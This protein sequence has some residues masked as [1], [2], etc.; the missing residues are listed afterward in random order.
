M[1]RIYTRTGDQGQTRLFSG[2]RVSKGHVRVE[3]YGQVDELNATLGV[4][5][6]SLSEDYPELRE[7]LEG[8][9]A[10]L[11]PIGAWLATTPEA[12]TIKSLKEIDPA[13]VTAL[14]SAIDRMAADLPP[15]PG[16]VLPSGHESAARAHVARTV[17]RRAER[18]VVRLCE[19]LDESPVTE[20]LRQIITYLNR[21]SDYLF[22]LA[23]LC[24]L[25]TEAEEVIWKP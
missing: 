9:Q 3:A 6:A 1:T 25:L 2:E 18:Q 12:P 13:R 4:L 22:T 17:C 8:I 19:S 23:R 20:Q 15:L 11:F 7:E 5:M 24:N 16:F 14:E 10:D 21:L